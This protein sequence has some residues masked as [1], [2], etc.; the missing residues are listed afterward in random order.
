MADAGSNLAETLWRRAMVYLREAKRLYAENH[1]D[2]A[3]VMAE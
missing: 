3:L 1:Y 2:V